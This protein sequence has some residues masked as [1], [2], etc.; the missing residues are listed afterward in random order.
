MR[1]RLRR[2]PRRY[3]LFGLV[4]L[5]FPVGLAHLATNSVPVTYAGVMQ[6]E[7]PS[8]VQLTIPSGIVNVAQDGTFKFQTLKATLTV[9]GDAVGDTPIDFYIG[10]ELICSATTSVGVGKAT[11]SSDQVYSSSDFTS[12]GSDPLQY[13]YFAEVSSGSFTGLKSELGHLEKM[14]G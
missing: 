12:L 5:L 7:I 2:Q 8:L 13:P 14:V 3:A 11:C 4:F 6:E 10:N 1:A 9:N